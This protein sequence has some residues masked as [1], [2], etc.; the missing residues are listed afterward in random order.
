MK[1]PGDDP[2]VHINENDI[3]VFLA[4]KSYFMTARW[5]KLWAELGN[6]KGT[7]MSQSRKDFIEKRF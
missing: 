5:G 6:G 4:M 3:P 7:T 2:I 1:L